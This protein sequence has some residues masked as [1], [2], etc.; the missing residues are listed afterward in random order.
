MSTIEL[1]F[2]IFGS[3][4]TMLFSFG[5]GIRWIREITEEDRAGWDAVSY[6]CLSIGAAV[7]FMFM[8][9]IINYAIWG[10]IK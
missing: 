6:W 5:M 2:K 10:T 4:L 7:L 3:L 9:F 8:L 1:L